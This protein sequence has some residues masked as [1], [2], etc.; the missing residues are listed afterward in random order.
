MAAA[1]A[2][3]ARPKARAGGVQVKTTQKEEV[4]SV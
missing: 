1:A 2:A 4:Y 3:A